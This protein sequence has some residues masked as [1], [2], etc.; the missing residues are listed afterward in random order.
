MPATNTRLRWHS[1]H[2]ASFPFR[3]ERRDF[4]SAPCGLW[5]VLQT[6]S[7]PCP[8]TTLSPPAQEAGIF[9][10]LPGFTSTGCES[11]LPDVLPGRIPFFVWQ[12]SHSTD[13]L[14]IFS[15]GRT[16]RLLFTPPWALWHVS[17]II[18]FVRSEPNLPPPRRIMSI[19]A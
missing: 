1:S 2:R 13:I 19:S 15:T 6:I 7:P 10:P 3:C 16:K 18:C 8:V 14:F 5:H 9:T 4:L 11:F 17:Q 12:T